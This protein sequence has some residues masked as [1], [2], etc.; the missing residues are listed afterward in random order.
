MLLQNI[1]MLCYIGIY[2]ISYYSN[3]KWP[4]KSNHHLFAVPARNNDLSGEAN[5]D[6]QWRQ[7]ERRAG[8]RNFSRNPENGSSN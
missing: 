8:H 5:G 3:K 4:A 1:T 7:A 2:P 6:G